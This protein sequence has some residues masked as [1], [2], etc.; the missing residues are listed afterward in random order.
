VP[1]GVGDFEA[2]ARQVYANLAAII[3]KVGGSWASVVKTTVYLTDERHI[4][5]FRAIRREAMQGHEPPN[6]LVIAA[7]LGSPELLVEVEAVLVLD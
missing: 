2:Q 5:P 7:A 1:A 3:A 6:T 4:E